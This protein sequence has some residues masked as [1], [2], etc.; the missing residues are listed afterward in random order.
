MHPAHSAAGEEGVALVTVA[1]W[2]PLLVLFASFAI[3]VGNW[4]VHDRH[5]QLQ[6]DAGAL[7]AAGDF[8]F[9][10]DDATVEATAREYSGTGGEGSGYNHQVGGTPPDE[11]H[12]ELNSPTYFDQ[13]SPIDETVAAPPCEAGM[14]DV[15]LTETDLPL[16]LRV[17]DLFAS[18]PFI[19]AHARVQIFKKRTSSGGLPV[20]VPDTNPQ[21][22][23]V[24]FVDEE[25]GEILASQELA[26]N[27]NLE[28]LA[29]WDNESEPLPLSVD[30]ERIGVRVALSG[31]SSTACGEP[32]VE[33][34]DAASGD[35]ILY[36]RG[37][38]M[39]GSGAQPGE[40]LARDAYLLP[41]SCD[42][43]FSSPE[44]GCSVGLHAEVDF[45]PCEEIGKV[46]A[47]LTAVA[48]GGSYPMTMTGCPAGTSASSW[49]TSG[50]PIPVAPGAGPVPVALEWAETEGSQGGDKCKTGG[51]NPC[52]GSFGVVQRSFA[53]SDERSG[54]IGLA[55]VW[56]GGAVWANSFERC[57]SVQPSCLH[58]LVVKIGIEQTLL[59]NA[60]TGEEPPVALRVFHEAENNPSQNQSLDCDPALP[61][62]RDEIA[63][64]C[65]PEY[66]RN[67][68]T[69]CPSPA[70]LWASPQ[71]WECAAVQ[72]GG[73]VNQVFQGMNERVHGSAGAS[74]CVSPSD[75]ASFAFPGLSPGDPRL[76]PVFLTPFG[77]FSGSGSDTVPVT[78]FAIF[79]VTGWAGQ[80][81]G[82]SSQ[83]ICPSDDPAEAGT[84]VGH[85]VKYVQ[86]LNDG[87]AGEETCDFASP[88]PCVAVLTE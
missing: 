72:T 84:I 25:T 47:E 1:L 53:G 11:V 18:V 17:A 43:Y 70:E 61:N 28:G 9:S 36:L 75:W 12:L 15:K 67:Q 4:F 76:L 38:S 35:G 55:Q 49:E 27:G 34:Y 64:G 21:R 39:E 63:L 29:I 78:N 10:C 6:A 30:R 56:E 48:A 37:Y 46:G 80:G 83:S 23:L 65:A 52:Q 69:A 73:A 31:A 82:N 7:A 24:T 81:E 5:L 87:S 32:L 59:E 77:S 20:A 74:E 54:P 51:G 45:G 40:P 57:S 8:S 42:P 22:A 26:R 14:I 68:G 16:F 66:A 13:P 60:E 50:A 44:A 58:A 2:L 79:Y 86:A 41:G 71:P 88:T 62:L 85:F 19:N 3:D 33:C